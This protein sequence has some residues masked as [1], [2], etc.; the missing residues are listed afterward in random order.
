MAG[1]MTDQGETF[2][3]VS[4]AEAAGILGVSVA[5]VRRRIRAGDLE[6][7]TVHRPQGTAFVVRMAVD[8]SSGVSDAYDRDQEPRSTT[9]TQAS[10]EQAMTALIQ[11]TIGTV[12]GPLVAELAASRQAIE[13]QA[14]RVADLERKNGLLTAE[15]HALEARTAAQDAEALRALFP[16]W[17][18]TWGPWVLGLLA[19]AIGAVGWLVLV[20]PR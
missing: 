16:S 8:A 3:R 10:P 12:L 19:L 18:R 13:R 2:Q 20:W 11:T 17:W 9:R 15:N 6:A 4:V 7:E 1:V 5:T 14:D